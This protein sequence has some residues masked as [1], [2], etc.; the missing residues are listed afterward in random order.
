MR[1]RALRCLTLSG[2]A[3][4]VFASF[5]DHNGTSQAAAISYY[6]LFSLFPFLLFLVTLAAFLPLAG[7]V[8]TLVGMLQAVMPASAL[9]LVRE[10]LTSL[11]TNKHGLLL[12]VAIAGAVW[13]ASSGVI[14]LMIALNA[15][16]GVNESRA[17]VKRQLMAMGLVVAGT[18]AMLVA[19]SA[20][21][22]GG[23]VGQWLVAHVWGGSH[24]ATVF[25]WL[26]WPIALAMLMSLLA[27][28]YYL[29]PDVKQEF[30]F[31][32]PGS[33]VASFL[34]VLSSFGFSLYVG[35]F[36]SYNKTYGS[37]GGVIVLIT[38][39]FLTGVV[40]V[41]GGEI[42]A[43]VEHEHVDGKEPGEKEPG[44]NAARARTAE[45]HVPRRPRASPSWTPIAAG[46]A[47]LALL[48][49]RR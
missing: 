47:L 35:R 10:H 36:D 24:A 14:Q 39:L 17:W 9:A 22:L 37:I 49:A 19:A 15:A 6:F 45:F 27:V 34:W 13:S 30:R 41:L 20:M 28:L 25:A 48:R 42:N 7:T 43:V 31:I 38:F 32:T 44:E 16:Y 46:V 40:F 8:D 26:R 11:V 21:I 18:L 3:R 2:L 1:L 23:D 4:K 29:L 5:A 33:I 12:A